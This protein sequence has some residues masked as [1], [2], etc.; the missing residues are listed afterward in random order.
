M[1]EDWQIIV[2]W[3]KDE[4]KLRPSLAVGQKPESRVLF[5]QRFS[6][7]GQRLIALVLL[8]TR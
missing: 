2:G 5:A 6:D 1:I 8:L 4:L 3:T 7:L